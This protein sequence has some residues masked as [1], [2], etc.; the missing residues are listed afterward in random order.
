ML[1]LIKPI[2]GGE[3]VR[4]IRDD[5]TPSITPGTCFDRSHQPE[6]NRMPPVSIQHTD[7][8]EISR[9]LGMRGGN[10]SGKRNR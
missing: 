2:A 7:A 4:G 9:I 1:G 5:P 8:A 10:Q 3:I 6:L